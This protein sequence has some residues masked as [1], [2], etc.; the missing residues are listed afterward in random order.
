M[1]LIKMWTGEETEHVKEGK[2]SCVNASSNVNKTR[3]SYEETWV[4]T[5]R[6]TR[7]SEVTEKTVHNRN[8]ERPQMNRRHWTKRR[9]TTQTTDNYTGCGWYVDHTDR[10]GCG[11]N[12]AAHS[13][14]L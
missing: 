13:L 4:E 5:L 2:T 8:L 9:Q 14:L 6:K 7:Y 12:S 1:K 11:L 3:R 10:P